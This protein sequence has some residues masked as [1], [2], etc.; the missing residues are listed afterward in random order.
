[1]NS[2]PATAVPYRARNAW[3][4]E[5]IA[6]RMATTIPP[7]A[8]ATARSGTPFGLTVASQPGAYPERDSENSIR[9]VRYR[10]ELALDDAAEMTT[11]FI[12]PAAYGMPTLAKARTNGLPVMPRPPSASCVHG[13]I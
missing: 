12:T 11:R 1:M 10:F 8:T 3:P 6:S 9:V 13:V 4:G 7:L 5:K 2:I